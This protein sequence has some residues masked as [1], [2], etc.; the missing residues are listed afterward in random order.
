MYGVIVAERSREV[1]LH[2]GRGE[3]SSSDYP[4]YIV[5]QRSDPGVFSAD[6]R[7]R[8]RYTLVIVLILLRLTIWFARFQN[9]RI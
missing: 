8:D 6:L 7:R 4:L 1:L 9:E 2:I 5:P 3:K